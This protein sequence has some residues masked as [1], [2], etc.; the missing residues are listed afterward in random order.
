MIVLDRKPLFLKIRFIYHLEILEEELLGDG[1]LKL[2]S[3][4]IP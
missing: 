3:K 4:S 2:V 1:T